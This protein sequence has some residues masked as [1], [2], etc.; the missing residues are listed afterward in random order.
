M[1][2]ALAC[3]GAA[4]SAVP[5]PAVAQDKP[6]R[7]VVNA[8]LFDLVVE[9]GPQRVLVLLAE[10][11]GLL[12]SASAMM[13]VA[14]TQTLVLDALPQ[15]EVS[16]VYR[17]EAVPAVAMTVSGRATLDALTKNPNVVRVDATV[18]GTGTLASVVPLIDAD[19]N[20]AAGNDGEG[21][22]AAILDTGIDS[23]HPDL[24]DDIAAG[25]ACFGFRPSGGFCPNG[26]NR[27]TGP[28]AGEDD[29]GHG[30]HVAGIVTSNGTQASVGVA[31]GADIV[32]I[33]VLDDCS[34]GGCFYDAGE[35]VAALDYVLANPG[36][37]VDLINMSLGTGAQFSGACDTSTSWTTAGATAVNALRAN[38]VTTFASA[39]NNSSGTTMGFPACLSNVIAV[40]ASDNNDSMA[41]FSQSNAVTD[42]VAPGVS[43]V[44]SLLGGGTITAS[45]T[46]MA[47]PAA[48]GCAALL[49]DSGEVSAPGPLESRLETSPVSITDP[50]N[51]LSLPRIVC[52]PPPV[53]TC[54]GSVVTVDLN[55]GQSPTSG[56]DVILGTPGSDVINGMD[57]NDVIC[58][59]GG[60]DVIG[61]NAGDDVIFGE[62]GDDSIFGGSGND[63]IRGD[64]GDDLLGGSSGSDDIDGGIG[65]DVISGGSDADG[66]IQGGSGNDAVNGGGGNDANVRGGG[67]NDT[68]SGNGGKDT[69][70]GDAGNDQVRGGQNDDTVNGGTGDDFVAGNAGDDICNGGA[71]TDTAAVNCETVTGVP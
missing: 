19:D 12:G 55:L 26:T 48:V 29:A 68:V 51:G 5:S 15:A 31:P 38:G 13:S 25:Q 21:I 56:D 22:V 57:G 66:L 14:N 69:V 1:V 62:D 35:V 11:A 58:G 71:G 53:A 9:D 17:F 41:F 24:V 42:I 49:L 23:D 60:D 34:F 52:G 20:Q 39:G 70:Y 8:P 44:S 10:P 30:T 27:Q 45:G 37:G 63:T 46:S 28:G 61:G 3:V 59:Q 54:N 40:A 7:E 32:A 6:E 65:A 4:L 18:G 64:A 43:V 16:D 50:T 67:G 33:K 36:L 2:I 47:S